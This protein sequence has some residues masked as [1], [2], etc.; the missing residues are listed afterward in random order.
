MFKW[1]KEVKNT[2]VNEQTDNSPSGWWQDANKPYVSQLEIE[3][4][5]YNRNERYYGKNEK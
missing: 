1:K 2:K 4:E 5:L 3:K